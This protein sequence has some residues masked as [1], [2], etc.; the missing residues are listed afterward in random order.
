MK[1]DKVLRPPK[2]VMQDFHKVMESS[3]STVNAQELERFVEWTKEFGEE[4]S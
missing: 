1:D 3:S 4:G 2:V